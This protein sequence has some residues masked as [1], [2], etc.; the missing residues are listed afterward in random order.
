MCIIGQKQNRDHDKADIIY[1]CQKTA[2]Q[3]VLQ[4]QTCN[5]K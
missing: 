4:T 2:L 5:L 1:F 3:Q